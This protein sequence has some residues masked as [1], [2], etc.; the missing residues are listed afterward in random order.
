M[1]PERG[2]ITDRFGAILAGNQQHWRALFMKAMAPEPDVVLENF[3]RLVPLSDE[4]KARITQDLADHPGYIPVLLKDWLDW[5]DMAA[6]EVNTPNL[7]GVI[8]E[9][10]ASRTYP[11]GPVAAHAVGYVGRPNQQEAKQDAV[12]AL[13][14]MRVGRTGAEDAD[15]LSL[16]GDPGFVQ[17]E[18]NV[19]GEV[20][21]VVAQDAGTPGQTVALGMDA[22]LQQ[23]AVQSLSL[24]HI[25]E[26]TRP[27]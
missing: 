26:P 6:I 11:L 23:L 13:P 24:I 27:Y 16:R 17:T 4:E 7:P 19:H 20:M 3:F 21:R 1:A 15:D 18:T 2:V 12:L 10:G 9:E 14:G 5:P 8:V 25:S 22:G